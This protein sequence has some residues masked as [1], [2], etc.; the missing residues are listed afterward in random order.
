MKRKIFSKLLMGA[1]LVASV[2]SFTSCK[3]YDD[4]IN[5]LRN[6]VEKRALQSELT[7]LQ[8]TVAGVQST[9]SDALAKATAAATATDLNSVKTELATVKANADKAAEAAA[10]GIKDAASA[11]EAAEVAQKAAEK[12]AAD[13]TAALKDYV[14]TADMEAALKEYVT[15]TAFKEAVD[16]FKAQYDEFVNTNNGSLEEMKAEIKKFK[17]TYAQIWSAVSS[18]SLYAA[19]SPNN[20]ANG[21]EI[22]DPSNKL[23]LAFTMSKLVKNDETSRYTRFNGTK[24]LKD[25]IFGKNDYFNGAEA[26][27]ASESVS[28]ADRVYAKFPTSVIVRVSPTNAELTKDDI[29]MMDASGTALSVVE[30]ESVAPYTEVLTRAGSTSGLWEI[31]FN[32]TDAT[33]A[34][35]ANIKTNWDLANSKYVKGGDGDQVLYAIAVN[36]TADADEERFVVS[37]YG[38][39]INDTPIEAYEGPYSAAIV[40]NGVVGAV[41]TDGDK[42]TNV[43][44]RTH[45]NKIG[46]YAAD[47][48]W[49]PND[50][51]SDD[52][53]TKAAGSRYGKDPVKINN[54]E[55][56]FVN[57]KDVEGNNGKAEYYYVTVDYKNA[58]GGFGSNSSEYNAWIDYTYGG[59][60]DKLLDPATDVATI[61]VTIPEKYQTGD[62][63]GFRIFAVNYDGT[64]VDPDGVPFEVWVGADKNAQS[65]T[66]NF[67]PTQ[68]NGE[69]FTYAFTPTVT[70]GTFEDD[71]Y[72]LF[73]N[74]TTAY[75]GPA[76]TGTTPEGRW[77]WE[78]LQADKSAA[79]K[80]SEVAYVKFTSTNVTLWK[81]AET[82]TGTIEFVDGNDDVV[83]VITV[84][85]TKVMPTEFKAHWK[86]SQPGDPANTN[87]YICYVEP[88]KTAGTFT[89]KW[90]A[91]AAEGFK[92]LTQA[93]QDLVPYTDADHNYYQFVISNMN[94]KN[95]AYT[96]PGYFPYF[97]AENDLNDTYE[98][99]KSHVWA[100]PALVD[101]A[102]VTH[103]ASW[104]YVYK[105]IS[106]EQTDKK[107]YLGF[108]KKNNDWYVAGTPF[109]ITYAC[110]L[111][112]DVMKYSWVKEL[113]VTV[114][115]WFPEL[116]VNNPSVASGTKVIAKVTDV[117]AVYN[118]ADKVYVDLEYTY[119]G[120]TYKNTTR[121]NLSTAYDLT[122]L[123]AYEN[124][125]DNDWFK[126]GTKKMSYGG[127][128]YVDGTTA[129]PSLGS[130]IGASVTNNSNGEAQYFT[131]EVAEDGL[132]TLTPTSTTQPEKTIES[133]LT[134]KA[135][136]AFGHVHEIAKLP[137]N[138]HRN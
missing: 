125:F 4:D 134:L 58:S 40:R 137:L 20:A 119:N 46:A 127:N 35:A 123:I 54:S 130:Y 124:S 1:L 66:G 138:V 62:Y 75:T 12:A 83:N 29:K 61:S 33:E 102:N 34:K 133:T 64:L 100:A 11:K 27:S 26:Y 72:I 126:N 115:T 104:Y 63:I 80:W 38:L 31:K 42:I 76:A 36:N 56:F 24:S 132:I 73:K 106:S 129:V 117:Y 59:D 69:E 93:I 18:I 17:D 101:N 22:Y 131:A 8:T 25:G 19:V 67:T 99:Y 136:D 86:E 60:I 47:K 121:K 88:N 98:N 14:K 32:L 79:T 112:P 45:V 50:A 23:N 53:T 55:S 96:E 77:K 37:E 28:Y 44:G 16:G 108:E 114:G 51:A 2:S 87:N 78:F 57:L 43:R 6:D 97:D 122:K 52:A 21:L 71:G 95:A 90:N 92:D 13:A 49:D 7:A 9:A 103:S 84:N 39:T 128:Y 110:A 91:T 85:L 109:T 30:V 81:D 65:I 41:G 116:I 111:N 15:A 82:G 113:E 120:V 89:T 94:L 68:N 5:S 10:Q 48:V 105:N 107:A 74:G 135:L 118:Q 70:T 3:D